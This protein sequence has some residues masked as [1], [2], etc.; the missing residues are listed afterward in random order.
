MGEEVKAGVGIKE[1]GQSGRW[2]GGVRRIPFLFNES[3][4]V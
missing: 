3:S 1:R 4:V 2:M